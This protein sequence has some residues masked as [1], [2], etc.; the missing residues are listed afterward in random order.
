MK[1]LQAFCVAAGIFLCL[2]VFH[3]QSSEAEYKS[4]IDLVKECIT[5][6]QHFDNSMIAIR[7]AK[8]LSCL[9]AEIPQPQYSIDD[10]D[11]EE[12]RHQAHRRRIDMK[13]IAREVIK[14]KGPAGSADR[15]SRSSSLGPAQSATDGGQAFTEDQAALF[16]DFFPPQA[17]FSNS[18]LF[19]ELFNI[20]CE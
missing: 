4:H 11:N 1:S 5:M 18:F 19:D 20:V 17:G 3:R 2:D 8:L 7:G 12:R 16:P 10:C 6:L 9:L 15:E 14:V 13:R